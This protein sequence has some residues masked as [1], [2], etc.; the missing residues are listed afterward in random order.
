MPTEGMFYNFAGFGLNLENAWE[1]YK[2]ETR[3]NSELHENMAL[4]LN[5]EST[6]GS[7]DQIE[8]VYR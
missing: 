6:K 8:Y 2:F 4:C 1:R 3:E 5:H 7:P